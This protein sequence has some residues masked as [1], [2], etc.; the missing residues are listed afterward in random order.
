MKKTDSETKKLRQS[1]CERIEWRKWSFNF[2]DYEA[3]EV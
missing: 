1:G 3:R 2:G